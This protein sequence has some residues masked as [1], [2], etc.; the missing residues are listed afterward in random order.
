MALM[1]MCPSDNALSDL[2][3]S[4]APQSAMRKLALKRGVQTLYQEGLHQVLAG[5]TSLEEI[6]CLSYTAVDSDWDKD[7][8]L[9]D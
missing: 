7:Q 9:S 4:N 2:I 6:A 8:P 3:S 5:N 1:E